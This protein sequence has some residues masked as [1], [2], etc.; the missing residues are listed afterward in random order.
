MYGRNGESTEG[1]Q[2]ADRGRVSPLIMREA[3]ILRVELKQ[4][5]SF[6]RLAALRVFTSEVR[7]AGARGRNSRLCRRLRLVRRDRP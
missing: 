1:K 7:E 4:R 2:S 5:S 3:I 6:Q